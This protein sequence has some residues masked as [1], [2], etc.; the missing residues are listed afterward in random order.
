MGAITKEKI[1]HSAVKCNSRVLIRF[2]SLS[3]RE[4]PITYL[5]LCYINVTRKLLVYHTLIIFAADVKK[6]ERLL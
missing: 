5:D 1:I 4:R 2:V 3:Q 6:T